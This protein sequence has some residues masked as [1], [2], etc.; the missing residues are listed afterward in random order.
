MKTK[1]ELANICQ[2]TIKDIQVG[3]YRDMNGSWHDFPNVE[4]IFYTNLPKKLALKYRVE[5]ERETKIYVLPTDT[6][7][8]AKT[9]GDNVC[10]LNMAS[11]YQAGGGVLNGSR[12]QEEE[13]CRRSTLMSGLFPYDKVKRRLLDL[14]MDKHYY[15]IPDYGGIYCGNVMVYRADGTYN[16][17]EEPYTCSVVSVAGI[18]NPILSKKGLMQDDD[19]LMFKGK[20]RSILRIAYI[21]YHEKLVLGALGCGAYHCPPKQVAALFKEVLQENEFKGVFSDICFAIIDDKNSKSNYKIFKE[22]IEI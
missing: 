4:S 1:E 11:S 12:A 21:H 2:D 15:P 14:S 18:K 6:F 7:L 9:L 3:G 8:G 17:L 13:L 22:C 19:V 20:I 10:V 5:K 16:K